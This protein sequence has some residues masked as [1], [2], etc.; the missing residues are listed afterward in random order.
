MTELRHALHYV[1]AYAALYESV[2][3]VLEGESNLKYL[4]KRHV[5]IEVELQAAVGVGEDGD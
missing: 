3:R 5:D 1:V 4:R 2:R